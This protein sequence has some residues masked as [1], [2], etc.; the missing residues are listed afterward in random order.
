[1]LS[2]FIIGIENEERENQKIIALGEGVTTHARWFGPSSFVWID[3]MF[4]RDYCLMF[5]KRQER[6]ANDILKTRGH[7]YL[8]EVYDILGL[9]RTVAGQVV[10][11]I[12]DENCNISFNLYSKEYNSEFINGYR[13]EALLDFNVNGIILDK[14]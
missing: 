3:Q 7:L 5:L 10:G 13:A 12:Y 1:M 4:D 8:N 14:I 11:W 6:Y 2:D 9:P